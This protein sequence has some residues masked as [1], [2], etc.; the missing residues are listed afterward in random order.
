MRAPWPVRPT[1]QSIERQVGRATQAAWHASRVER[2][3]RATS[4]SPAWQPYPGYAPHPAPSCH[5]IGGGGVPPSWQYEFFAYGH[6]SE[7]SIGG[8]GGEG[9]GA[10]GGIIPANR[11]SAARLMPLAVRKSAA[12]SS[13]EHVSFPSPRP[14][15]SKGLLVPLFHDTTAFGPV[16]RRVVAGMGASGGG[17]GGVGGEGGG[18]GA[19]VRVHEQTFTI[20]PLKPLLAVL[21]LKKVLPY[22]WKQ[23]QG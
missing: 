16:M 17:G 2:S 21:G 3:W 13:P 6:S 15:H 20:S 7:H 23:P 10:A 5:V 11:A 9:G 4:F 12:R 14:V 1:Y 8:G 22:L 19:V 18:S